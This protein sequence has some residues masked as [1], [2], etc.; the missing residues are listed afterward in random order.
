MPARMASAAIER[1]VDAG[2]D[3]DDEPA[4]REQRHGQQPGHREGDA[5][6][7]EPQDRRQDATLDELAE[8]GH[9]E[10]ADGGDDVAGRTLSA[11]GET[12]KIENGRDPRAVI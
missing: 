11:H 2:K 4:E 10:A 6:G 3:A 9:E 1:R 7:G 8:A 12:P 5:G